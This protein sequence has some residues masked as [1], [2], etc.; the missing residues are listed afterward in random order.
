[1][2][3]LIFVE[4]EI[5]DDP[6]TRQLFEEDI[7]KFEKQYLEGY[8]TSVLDE[9]QYCKDVGSKLKYL[10]DKG[11]KIWI[12]GRVS[13]I[14]LYPFSLQEF[15]NL[16]GQKEVTSTMLKRSVW[17]H[18]T[19]GGYPIAVGIEDPEIKKFIFLYFC[20]PVNETESGQFLQRS[21]SQ[22]YSIC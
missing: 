17:E 18:A 4:R 11:K 13:I 8:D 12:V 9:V 19:Y 6:D 22:F 14:K 20:D 16:K 3:A 10:A 5:D 1:M 7:K 21:Y 2:F 15:L